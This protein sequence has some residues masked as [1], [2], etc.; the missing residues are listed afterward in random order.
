M[1]DRFVTYIED[2]EYHPR[3]EAD[4]VCEHDACKKPWSSPRIELKQEVPMHSP[5]SHIP[6]AAYDATSAE[7]PTAVNLRKMVVG[8]SQLIA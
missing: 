8:C 5:G 4:E 7:I 2:T 3:D 6:T 1:F